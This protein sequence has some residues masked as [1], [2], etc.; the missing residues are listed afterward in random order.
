MQRSPVQSI[1]RTSAITL[2]VAAGLASAIL[3]TRGNAPSQRAANSTSA[4][5][6]ASNSASPSGGTGSPA[7]SRSDALAAAM[8]SASGRASEES[9]LTTWGF[10]SSYANNVLAG[11]ANPADVTPVPSSGVQVVPHDGGVLISGQSVT[12][13][14]TQVAGP[15]SSEEVWLVALSGSICCEFGSSTP[16]PWAVYVYDATT[17]A[18]LS[19]LYG[20]PASSGAWPPGFASIQDLAS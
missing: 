17:G 18:P 15:P 2:V 10:V 5:A 19:V 9:K 20:P 11:A 6:T 16:S 1:L 3:I 4:P 8:G 13:L 14:P 12:P 7:F